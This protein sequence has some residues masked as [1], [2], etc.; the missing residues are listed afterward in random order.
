[1]FALSIPGDKNCQEQPEQP[2]PALWPDWHRGHP[3]DWWWRTSAARWDH[4]WVQVRRLTSVSK[5][6]ESPLAHTNVMHNTMAAICRQRFQNEFY[7]NSS[8]IF[9]SNFTKVCSWGFNWQGFSISSGNDLV[10]SGNKPLP[11]PMIPM[12]PSSVMPM[13]QLDMTWSP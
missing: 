11:E 2:L 9:F 8:F 7:W 5:S 12:M 6:H 3:V 4:I 10:S 13:G 1:M